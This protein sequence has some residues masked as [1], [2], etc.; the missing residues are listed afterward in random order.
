MKKFISIILAVIL[1]AGMTATASAASAIP[2]VEEFSQI[3]GEGGNIKFKDQYYLDV[4]DPGILD[5]SATLAINNMANGLFGAE[6]FVVEAVCVFFYY[7]STV[8]IAGWMQPS[9]SPIQK[10]LKEK[11]FDGV[12]VLFIGLSFLGM[13]GVLFRRNYPE[14][15]SRLTQMVAV[16]VAAALLSIY[17]LNIAN[18]LNSIND[19]VTN[20]IMASMSM[21]DTG[22]NYTLTTVGTLW[23]SLV[24]EPWLMLEFDE[25]S[26]TDIGNLKTELLNGRFIKGSDK[27]QEEIDKRYEDTKDSDSPLFNR[28]LP[29]AR[30]WFLLFYFPVLLAKCAIYFL[31]AVAQLLFKVITIALLLLG[32]IVLLLSLIPWFGGMK[33][34]EKWG[35]LILEMQIMIWIVTFMLGFIVM[36]DSLV[37]SNAGFLGWFFVLI[38]QI[39]IIVGVFLLR[40]KIFGLFSKAHKKINPY[41][42]LVAAQ[43]HAQNAAASVAGSVSQGASTAYNRMANVGSGIYGA[44]ESAFHKMQDFGETAYDKLSG[45]FGS[46]S[47]GANDNDSGEKPAYNGQ[48][49][50][51]HLDETPAAGGAVAAARESTTAQRPSLP[52]TEST[53]SSTVQ[54]ISGSMSNATTV[55]AGANEAPV[56]APNVPRPELSGAEPAAAGKDKATEQSTNSARYKNYDMPSG[57]NDYTSIAGIESGAGELPRAAAINT[58]DDEPP[59]YTTNMQHRELPGAEPTAAGKDEAPEHSNHSTGYENYDT[60]SSANDRASI[61]EIDSGVNAI[62][63][64]TA[65][66]TGT[67]ETSEYAMAERPELATDN[68]SELPDRP[69]TIESKG[70][71]IADYANS[72]QI[73]GLT[74]GTAQTPQ[75]GPTSQEKPKT[76]DYINDQNKTQNDRP[77]AAEGF[78]FD[79]SQ[80]EPRET[81]ANNGPGTKRPV[82]KDVS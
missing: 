7:A 46:S 2:E 4:A 76:A 18:S 77:A 54:T 17:S 41:L 82:L 25:A 64:E 26:D 70:E 80:F 79:M 60:S 63:L 72:R 30:F 15:F 19:G 9:I 31:V 10:S 56:A 59:E 66:S 67:G 53:G 1:A 16:C 21:S 51:P 57:A 48:A 73:A 52:G 65:A 11:L 35:F 37:Y 45:Y 47:D 49:E 40:K 29:G 78:N 8:D 74:E 38:L 5:T 44:G 62:S 12:I 75:K 20:A 34:L 42:N 50:R 61:A 81:T 14:V 22:D 3:T 23:Q 69:E 71:D 6:K 32:I 33:L 39:A 27:R 13:A 58:S 43:R 24:H 36:I 55:I 28:I 68:L